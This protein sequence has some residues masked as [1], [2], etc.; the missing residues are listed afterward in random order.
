MIVAGYEDGNDASN[1][2]PRSHVQDGA[3]LVAIRP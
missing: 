2:S 1:L 3:G